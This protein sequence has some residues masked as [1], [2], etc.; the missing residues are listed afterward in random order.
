MQV[1]KN[2]S[3][4]LKTCLKSKLSKFTAFSFNYRRNTD[5]ILKKR[6]DYVSGR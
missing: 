5:V 1:R 6:N 4:D 2:N 3:S